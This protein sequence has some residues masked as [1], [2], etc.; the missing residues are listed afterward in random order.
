LPYYAGFTA[1]RPGGGAVAAFHPAGVNIAEF[2]GRVAMFKSPLLPE[3]VL[4]ALWMLYAAATLGLVAICLR[5]AR[6]S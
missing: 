4:V 3:G 5:L 6:E 1:H 2:V